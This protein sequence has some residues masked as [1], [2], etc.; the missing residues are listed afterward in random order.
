MGAR[1]MKTSCKQFLVTGCS[2]L[3]D[4]SANDNLLKFQPYRA[5]HTY[6]IMRFFVFAPEKLIFVSRLIAR[7][8]DDKQEQISNIYRILQD[9]QVMFWNS[10]GPAQK[11]SFDL[12]LRL[13][14]SAS[15]D[16]CNI[17]FFLSLN[18][19]VFGKESN[20]IA[21]SPPQ[22]P[23]P[24]SCIAQHYCTHNNL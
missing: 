14:F 7:L 15:Y 21:M 6:T 20:I 5:I 23:D 12:K 8:R 11:A 9:I 13:C 16:T 22:S 10:P 1:L 2:F 3:I 18:V 24:Y 4:W 17:M 19:C